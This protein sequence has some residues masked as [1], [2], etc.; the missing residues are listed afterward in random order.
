MAL[1]KGQTLIEKDACMGGVGTE[2]ETDG[3]ED[4]VGS[5]C[6]LLG[7]QQSRRRMKVVESVEYSMVEVLGIHSLGY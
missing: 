6:L 4:A 2:L 3:G 7:H 1:S 5:C